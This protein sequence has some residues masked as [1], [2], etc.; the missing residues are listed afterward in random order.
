M[1]KAIIFIVIAALMLTVTPAI[2]YAVNEDVFDN[3]KGTLVNNPDVADDYD[4]ASGKV[5]LNYNS[6]EDI[7][8][9]NIVAK[10]LDP[11]IKYQAIFHNGTITTLGCGYPNSGGVLHIKTTIPK[12]QIDPTKTFSAGEARVNVRLAAPGGGCVG[13]SNSAVL[14]TVK[15]W[16]GTG[17]VPAGSNRPE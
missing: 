7:W 12:N 1:K 2:I 16:G 14:S 6:E 11:E 10:G 8:V 3:W 15:K 5:I 9:V 13:I 4:D 17:L